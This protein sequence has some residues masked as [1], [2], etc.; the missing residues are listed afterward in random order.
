MVGGMALALRDLGVRVSGTEQFQIP[1]MPEVLRQA[2]IG[3]NAEWSAENL[4]SKVDAESTFKFVSTAKKSLFS[5]DRRI[6]LP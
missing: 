6:F 1:P 5:R 4:P 2:G 3:V